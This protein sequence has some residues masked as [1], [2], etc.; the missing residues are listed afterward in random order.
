MGGS[1]FSAGGN[2]LFTPRMPRSVYKAIKNRCCASLRNIYFC[3]ACPIDGPGKEDFGDVD[4]LLAWPKGVTNDKEKTLNAITSALQATRMIA[5]KGTVSAHFALPWP[6]EILVDAKDDDANTYKAAQRDPTQEVR[7]PLSQTKEFQTTELGEMAQISHPSHQPTQPQTVHE[8][9]QV[10]EKYI[11]VDVRVCDSLDQLQWM[12]FK[13]A[14]GDI[15]NLLGTTIRPYGLSVDEGA[16][17]LRIPEIENVH[18]NRAKVFLSSDPAE[19]LQFLDLPIEGF[20]EEPFESLN[21]MYEYVARCRLFWVHPLDPEQEATS[22]S[23]EQD[24]KK[25]KANDRKRMNQRPG[26]RRW[27]EEFKPKCREEGRFLTKPTTREAVTD[28]C[29]AWFHVEE[30]FTSRRQA[31]LLEKQRDMVWKTLIKGSIP[32]VESADPREILYRSCLVKALKRIILEGDNRYGILP[33]QDLKDEEGFYIEE[34]VLDFI[35]LNQ[36]RVGKVA[37]ELNHGNYIEHLKTKAAKK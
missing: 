22:T 23:L 37:I 20:W 26:F 5:D 1:A 21:A 24:R 28:E 13:H 3:V 7:K 2:P 8:P 10:Q 9:S 17:W 33:E 4:I 32:E 35:S 34:D 25:L 11:Q 27:V 15:W 36:D 19:I 31:F 14:H 30:E 12:L 6:E 29:F 16:L 18:R